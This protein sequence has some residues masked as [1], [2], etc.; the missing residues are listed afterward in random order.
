M[1]GLHP[2]PEH[3]NAWHEQVLHAIEGVLRQAEDKPLFR[4]MQCC[5]KRT[6][7]WERLL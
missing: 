2:Y 7:S 3:L 6:R 1:T 4:H 5:V